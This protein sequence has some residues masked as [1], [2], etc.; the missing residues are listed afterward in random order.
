MCKHVVGMAIRLNYCKPSP[1]AKN[2]KIGEKRR[3]GRVYILALTLKRFKTKIFA[4]IGLLVESLLRSDRASYLHLL[5][6]IRTCNNLISHET[7][8]LSRP[9]S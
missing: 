2:I 9:C 5:S 6:F 4:L 7:L 1:A 8:I 3:F